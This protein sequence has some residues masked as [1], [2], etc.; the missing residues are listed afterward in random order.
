MSAPNTTP[1]TVFRRLAVKRGVT[2]ASLASG[3]ADEFR[4]ALAA[5]AVR[6]T[7]HVAHSEKE[8]NEILRTFLAGAGAMLAADHVELRRWLVDNRLLDR[9]GFGRRYERAATPEPFAQYAASFTGADLDRSAAEVRAADSEARAKR[10]A[11]YEARRG[12]P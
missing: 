3:R 12:G 1:D 4:A 5:A 2:L 6:F 9:D 10:R 11:R 7:P 8:V